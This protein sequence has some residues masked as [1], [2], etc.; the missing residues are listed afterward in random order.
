LSFD[1]HLDLRNEY[2]DQTVCH[3]TFIR[4][5]NETIKP[6]KIIEVG[7]RAVCKEEIDYAM[8]QKIA[9]ITSQRIMHVGA[10]DAAKEINRLL[11][12][13]ESVYLTVDMDVLDPAFAPA[14]Q[15]PEP[16]GLSTH[17]LL[18]LLSEICSQRVIAFDIV[19]VTPHYDTGATAIQAAKI[20]FEIL[21]HIYK[22]TN[23]SSN[24]IEIG[25]KI[26]D[27]EA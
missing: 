20:I 3:A 27:S 10:E 9:Y 1:A 2:M 13:Y 17:M 15:N 5:I 25:D 6:S 16:D 23:R 18:D 12:D 26:E 7:T 19:E 14:V 22:E 4:R 8:G 21:S 24:T 11:A